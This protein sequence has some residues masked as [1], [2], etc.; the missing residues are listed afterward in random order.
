MGQFDR[1]AEKLSELLWGP[2][3]VLLVLV[4]GV[5][6]S[7]TNGWLQLRADVWLGSIRR[8]LR[9]S[10]DD[11]KAISPLQ[12]AT[13]ALAGTLGTGNIVGVATALTLGGPGAVFWM[14]AAALLGMIVSY[15]ETVLGML[16]RRRA[17]GGGWQG[18]PML[19]M[20][21]CAGGRYIAAVWAVFCSVAAFGV[22]NLTQVNSI[23]HSAASAWGV[24]QWITCAVVAV[25]AA[26]V[27][28]RGVRSA[29]RL[30]EKLIPAMTVIYILACA[31]VIAVNYKR[32]PAAFEAIFSHIF[33][34]AAAGGGIF[35]AMMVGVRRGIFTNEAGLGSSVLLHTSADSDHPCT[36]GM[37]G[38][39]E[40][41]ADTIVMC[42]MTALVILTGDALAQTD[43]LG[44]QLDGAA[45]S[46]AAFSPV[47]GSFSG[48]FITIS[49][50][51]FA[52]A[53]IISWGCCGERAFS[54]LCSERYAFVYRLAYVL[55]IIPG[56]LAKV[57]TVWALSDI[58]NGLMLIPNTVIIL[59]LWRRVSEQTKEY[60][61]L[62]SRSEKR[63]GSFGIFR[64]RVLRRT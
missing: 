58:L 18:G 16:Y 60:H 55:A 35:G 5:W 15:A 45:L 19:Y 21:Q 49:L 41:F 46:A 26:P 29:A 2:W 43:A 33:T 7:V 24:P 38:I 20:E 25:L 13:A 11:E 57:R 40:V 22:G 52:F 48:S 47:F 56:G 31:A 36:Q 64:S 59:F 3:T 27:I 4:T 63:S 17:E 6:F 28:L 30:T 12:S 32:V 9:R 62:Y 37:W 10:S 39:F 14:W 8:S 50:V 1:L 51:L 34:P 44:R 61:R 42:T 54:Y 23:A 53:T